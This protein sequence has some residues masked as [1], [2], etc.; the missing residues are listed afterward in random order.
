MVNKT[1]ILNKLQEYANFDKDVDFAKF[2][3]IGSQTL[4]TWKKRNTFKID[5]LSIKFPEIN[6]N[7]LLTGDGDMIEKSTSTPINNS[8]TISMP[9][10]VWEVIKNQAE[11]LKTKDAQTTEVIG[12]LKE[13]LKKSHTVDVKSRVANQITVE[14]E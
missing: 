7:W 14:D 4:Y 8:N 5:I 9:A 12:M 6:N 11:S 10:D 3:G 13:Q 2:L 1:L